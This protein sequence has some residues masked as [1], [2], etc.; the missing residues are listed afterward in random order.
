MSVWCPFGA[1]TLQNMDVLG[2]EPVGS[3]I[4]TVEQL[5]HG[6]GYPN[7]PIPRIRDWS[8]AN[9]VYRPA[10]YTAP[11]VFVE[12]PEPE[13]PADWDEVWNRALALT[14]APVL[15]RDAQGR[16]LNPAGRTGISGRGRLWNWGP[17]LSGDAIVT[18]DTPAGPA[19]LL[20]RRSDTGQ[21]AVPGGFVEGDEHSLVTAQRELKEE[22]GIRLDMAARATLFFRGIAD[23]AVRNTDHAWIESTAYHIHLSEAEAARLHPVAGDDA[24]EV[25]PI[26]LRD[27][28]LTQLSDNHADYLTEI[29]RRLIPA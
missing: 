13:Q 22:T 10:Y 1:S 3:P 20:I 7:S 15:L 17:N 25:V 16:P 9:G 28:D 12:S 18:W 27:V 2:P 23:R 6:M 24:P 5:R 8:I 29:K 11:S 21:L 19:I 26:L 14:S 4:A